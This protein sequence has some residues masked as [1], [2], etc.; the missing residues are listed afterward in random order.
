MTR[1][2]LVTHLRTLSSGTI[3]QAIGSTSYRIIDRSVSNAIIY[4]AEQAAEGEI[5]MIDDLAGILTFLTEHKDFCPSW[6]G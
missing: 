2:E 1:S 3:A 6:C 4:A 5:A